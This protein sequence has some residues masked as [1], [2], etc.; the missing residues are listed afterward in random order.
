[1]PSLCKTLPDQQYLQM[2]SDADSIKPAT[3]KTYISLLKS[4]VTALD[5]PLCEIMNNPCQSIKDIKSKFPV[6][7]DHTNKIKTIVSIM[8]HVKIKDDIP[9][10]FEAWVREYKPLSDVVNAAWNNNEHTSRTK[11]AA[12]T[13]REI[14][15]KYNEIA[16][17]KPFS[18]E[19]V[20]L[21]M[22]VLIP[23]RRQEDY[24]KVSIGKNNKNHDISGTLDITVSPPILT[25]TKYKTAGTYNTWTK[26]LPKSLEIVLKRFLATHP[27]RKYLFQKQDGT[28]FSCAESFRYANNTI[29]RRVL[30]NA[31]ASVNV[32]RHAAATFVHNHPKYD[33]TY[34]RQYAKDMGHSYETQSHY[35]MRELVEKRI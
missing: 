25:I 26:E 28:A 17:A 9:V 5:K 1:M 8:K 21:A 16:K 2:I 18:L 20:T 32:L 33:I 27:D 31:K 23:P 14:V 6:V 7:S 22:Y 12:M 4:I 3:K 35:M 15:N 19:H 13:W 34:K 10:L 30:G 11:E 24:W 29:L